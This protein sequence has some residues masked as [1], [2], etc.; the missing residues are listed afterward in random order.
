MVLYASANISDYLMSQD[1]RAVSKSY[2]AKNNANFDLSRGQEDVSQ[3]SRFWTMA[4]S[5]HP[6]E[7]GS[8]ASLSDDV[9]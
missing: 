3:F 9:L 8:S 1:T 4:A 7:P 5:D 2:F 6:G